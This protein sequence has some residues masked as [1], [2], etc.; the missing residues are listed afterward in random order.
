[1]SLSLCLY[2]CLFAI[3]KTRSSNFPEL[4]MM[5]PMAR[6][7]ASQVWSSYL[8][9]FANNSVTE[10]SVIGLQNKQQHN[11]T[12]TINFFPEKGFK[13]LEDTAK[14]ALAQYWDDVERS[15]KNLNF[16]NPRWRTAAI[17]KTVKSPYLR[18]RLTDVDEI[19]HGDADWPPTGDILLKFGIKKK[20]RWR[21][22]PS[23]K[24]TK[25]AISQQRVDRSSSS[26]NLAWLC[27]MGLLSA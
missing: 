2:V 24:T 19:W 16:Q 27:K 21:R 23:W 11:N 10:T 12:N 25:I 22:P 14:K 7:T 26:R 18:N 6:S 1:M 9:S 5:M 13:N 15:L 20:T 17:W 4:L 8:R 3:I